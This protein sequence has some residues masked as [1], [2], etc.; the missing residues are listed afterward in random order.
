MSARRARAAKVAL[1]LAVSSAVTAIVSLAGCGFGEGK[2]SGGEAT[3]TVS[4]DYGAERLV[5]ATTVDPPLTDTVMRFLDREAEIETRYGG[6]FVE[7]I[8]GISGASEAERRTDWFFYVNGSE[9][10]VGAAD[11]RLAADVRVWWDHHDWTDV[12]RVPA[13]VGSWPAPFSTTPPGEPAELVCA[14]SEVSACDHVL[15]RI[16]EAGGEVDPVEAPAAEGGRPVVLVGAWDDLRENA[17]ARALEGTPARSGVFAR[18]RPAGDGW[19]IEPYDAALEPGSALGAG[20]GLIAAVEGEP[21]QP[22]WVVTGTDD[23]GLS[24]A[25]EALS[26]EALT[27]RFSVVIAAGEEPQALP[28]Q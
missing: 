21:E 11:V 27:D 22:V 24:A 20:A 7:T 3:M 25:A 12:I 16:E 14:A 19:E 23:A 1:A 4:R 13:V 18:F 17:D 5:E 8:N 26:G 15:G 2:T 9:S 10:P 28:Q 6:G